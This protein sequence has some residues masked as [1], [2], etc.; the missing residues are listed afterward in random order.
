LPFSDV[1]PWPNQIVPAQL[2]DEIANVIH[3]FIILDAEEADAVVLWIALTWFIDVV[4]VLALLLIN[5]PELGCAKSTLLDLVGR[6]SARSLSTS[7]TSTAAL[8]RAIELWK[9]TLLIDEID[10]FIRE[11]YELKGLINAGH[12]RSS[13]YV[14]RTV[15]ENHEPKRFNLW[16]AKA[17]AGITLEKH[18]PASTM[19]RGILINMRRKMRHETVNR[20]RHTEPGLFENIVSKLARFS[21]DYSQQVRLARPVLPDGLNDRARDNWEPLL[22]IAACAGPEWEKRAIAAALELSGAGESSVSIGNELLADIQYIFESKGVDKISTADLIDELIDDDENPWATYNRGKPITA[23]Q[24]AKHLSG[25]GIKSKTVRHKQGTPKGY[26]LG[27]FEDVFARYLAS[28]EN[29]PQ[30]RN[31]SHEVMPEPLPVLE[32]GVVADVAAK[33]EVQ[34]FSS[35]GDIY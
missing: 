27:Q 18:L 21:D 13:A 6:M 4:E 35:L 17:F 12:S 23:R 28:S 22:A 19:S 14:L 26:D 10:T 25:Y 32:C 15:G 3:S 9:P 29:L 2:L 11:N 8:F 34:E 30:P 24:L 16:G 33:E 7:N 31:V 1:E 5:A 20:L